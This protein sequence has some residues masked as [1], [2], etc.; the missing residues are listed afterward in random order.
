M[1]DHRQGLELRSLITAQGELRLSLEPVSVPALQPDEVL[2][3]LQAA[4]INPSDLGLLVGPADIAAA[5]AQGEGAERTLTAPIPPP[6]LQYVAARL[7]QSMPVGN[8]GAGKVVDAGA[9]PQ[10]QALVGKTVSAWGGGMYARYRVVKLDACLPL[11]DGATAADGASA[12]VNPLTALGMVET[13]RAEGHTGLV[14]TAAASNLGQMLNRICLADGVPLVNI[15]R[16]PEQAA[17]LRGEGAA[18]V[19]DSSA[20]AFAEDL[21]A[22]MKATGATLAFDAIGGGRLASDILSA[23]ETVAS[24][25]AA[26]SRY[27]SSSRKQVYIYGSLDLGPTTLTRSFGLSWN[28]GGWLLTYF[29]QRAGRDTRARLQARVTSELKT[30][31]ASRYTRT[32]S[33]A[34]ALEP[35]TFRAYLRRATGEKYLIDPSLEP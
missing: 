15:V 5:V 11:P 32:V 22:A 35:D 27:G 8:E 7:D 23:M 31:F 18:H 30:T 20:A 2:L 34:Q 19:C 10:A 14:H 1:T 25:G 21:V 13:L 29:L 4:P 6:L 33:L 26:Y 12:F 9:S 16:S 3:E 24:A 28:V 17:I